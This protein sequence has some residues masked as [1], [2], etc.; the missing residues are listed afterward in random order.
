MQ[1]SFARTRCLFGVYTGDTHS[2]TQMCP[3][4][5][6]CSL[7]GLFVKINAFYFVVTHAY[8]KIDIANTMQTQAQRIFHNKSSAKLCSPCETKQIALAT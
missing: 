6:T 2:L 3:G 5:N 4:L 7:I 1:C 8:A